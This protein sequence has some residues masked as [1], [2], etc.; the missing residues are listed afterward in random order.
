MRGTLLKSAA[1]A[2]VTLFDCAAFAQSDNA[3]RATAQPAEEVKRAEVLVLGVYHMS[4]PGR[5]I[6]NV[7]ADDVLVPKR[8]REIAEH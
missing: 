6:F 1:L 2:C 5:D 8:Q 7:Q 4:N 3:T